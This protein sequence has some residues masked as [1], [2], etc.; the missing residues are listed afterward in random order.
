MP[1]KSCCV[2]GTGAWGSLMHSH[3]AS[4]MSGLIASNQTVSTGIVNQTGMRSELG[5]GS[6]GNPE[7]K[8][9]WEQGQWEGNSPEFKT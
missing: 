5:K 9:L 4:N 3:M 8:R 1:G 7:R 2:N 6:G